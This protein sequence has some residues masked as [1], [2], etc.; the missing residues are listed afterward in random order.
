[1]RRKPSFVDKILTDGGEN[2]PPDRYPRTSCDGYY[3]RR[4]AHKFRSSSSASCRVCCQR[5]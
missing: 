1:M 5:P 2:A 3:V 4:T